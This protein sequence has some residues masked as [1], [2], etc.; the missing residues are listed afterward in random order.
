[1]ATLFVEPAGSDPSRELPNHA[2]Q[3]RLGSAYCWDSRKG[4]A[5]LRKE[6]ARWFRRACCSQHARFHRPALS[7]FL[8]LPAVRSADHPPLPL[9]PSLWGRA[10][11]EPAVSAPHHAR[12]CAVQATVPPD[13][14]AYGRGSRYESTAA[15]SL[16]RKP[17]LSIGIHAGVVR[18]ALLCQIGALVLFIGD[19]VLWQNTVGIPAY[20]TAREKSYSPPSR[21]PSPFPTAALPRRF[22]SE[23][24]S[25]GHAGKARGTGPAPITRCKLG[26]SRRLRRLLRSADSRSDPR[27]RPQRH[28]PKKIMFS[29][30]K[31]ALTLSRG[32]HST[33]F[34]ESSPGPVY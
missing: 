29:D 22:G 8:I 17:G 10:Q 2:H 32:Q 21:P 1:M 3:R 30:A 15:L 27:H 33:F 25:V 20:K 11:A 13:S 24:S 19:F 12:G 7:T 4:T 28:R 9:P 26:V 14:P 23:T 5:L 18:A 6:S 16:Y 31:W 34:H